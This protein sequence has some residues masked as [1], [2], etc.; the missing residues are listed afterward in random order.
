MGLGLAE[1]HNLTL[2]NITEVSKKN[3]IIRDQIFQR[4]TALESGLV[5]TQG[6][7]EELS[8]QSFKHAKLVNETLARES[9]RMEKISSAMEKHT[10][11]QM[12]EIKIQL[13]NLDEKTEKWRINFEDSESKKL[14]E[15]HSAM[16]ILNSNFQKVSRDS[17]DR[18]DLQ[19]QEFHTFDNALKNQLSDMR[20][21]VEMELRGTEERTEQATVKYIAKLQM[22]GVGGG[23]GF[24]SGGGIN[25]L[26]LDMM[27]NSLKE[28]MKTY[29]ERVVSQNSEKLI[30]Q[31]H[32]SEMLL[33]GRCNAYSVELER[34]Y[35]DMFMEYKGELELADTDNRI[36]QK[37]LLGEMLD[38]F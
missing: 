5:D 6:K 34:K 12:N 2:E 25:N 18:F 35:R 10:F 11:G 38:Q 20:H 9:A 27:F 30:E 24:L 31:R 1:V 16:K 33:E 17:K 14:L 32:N 22:G 37:T 21:K 28:E 29:A 3:E 23:T 19:Q 8:D 26:E 15:L 7:L 13:Q 36:H 4:Q